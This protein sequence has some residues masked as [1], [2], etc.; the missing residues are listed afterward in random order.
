[1]KKV[2][3][4]GKEGQLARCLADVASSADNLEL[5][6]AARSGTP[7]ALDLLDETSIRTAVRTVKPH[8]IVNAAAYTAVDKAEEET[9]IALKINGVAP[10]ILAQEAAELGAPLI[11]V[12]TDYVFD[13]L[14]DRPYRPSD[15][16]CPASSYG[17]SKLVGEEAVREANSNHI[18]LRTAW[19]YSPYGRNFC[20]TMLRLAGSHDELNVVD[21]QYGCPTNATDLAEVI[22]TQAR[23]LLSENRTRMGFGTYHCTNAGGTS[24]FEFAKT[25]FELASKRLPKIPAVKPIPTSAYPTPAIRPANSMLDCSDLEEVFGIHLR[26]WENALA[27]V[28]AKPE[29]Y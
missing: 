26:P 7:I 8:L 16:P 29:T 11:Q 2:L 3:V 13:G 5:V 28:L 17:R 18:V 22:L 21:D 1:M 24:W 25:I 27:S 10:G 12:S 14:Q 4:T 19:V 9:D 20:K 6:F 15:Q 23:L